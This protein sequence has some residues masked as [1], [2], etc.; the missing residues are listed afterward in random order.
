MT[1]KKIFA[2]NWKLN[3]TPEEAREFVISFK[4]EVFKK[5]DFF[6]DKEIIKVLRNTNIT[7][8]LINAL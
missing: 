8:V 5:T 4:N 1:T 2:A 7:N 6:A 3:K